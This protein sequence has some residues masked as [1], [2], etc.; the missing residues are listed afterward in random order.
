MT[1]V[2]IALSFAVLILGFVVLYL[3]LAN[4]TRLLSSAA[5]RL[6]RRE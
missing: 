5:E 4:V 3:F 6:S 1:T 2:L